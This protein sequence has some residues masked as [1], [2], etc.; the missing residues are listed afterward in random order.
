MALKIVW[1]PKALEGL[2]S[3]LDYLDIHWTS[4]EILILESKIEEFKSQVERTP[5]IYPTTGKHK[6]IRKAV[7]S[8][9]NYIIYRIKPQKKVIEIIYFKA[10]KQKPD[11]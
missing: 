1:T 5:F 10:S 8:K 7:L 6:Y 4:K 3:V 9:H 2:D 11:S